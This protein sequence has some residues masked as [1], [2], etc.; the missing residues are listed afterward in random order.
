MGTKLEDTVRYLSSA[1]IALATTCLC[2]SDVLKQQNLLNLKMENF[3][4]NSYLY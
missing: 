2:K 1:V 3:S 4:S